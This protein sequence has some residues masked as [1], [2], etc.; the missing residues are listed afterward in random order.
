[1]NNNGILSLD[2]LK[3]QHES[4]APNFLITSMSWGEYSETWPMPLLNLEIG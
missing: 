3:E 2:H 1:M 4:Y